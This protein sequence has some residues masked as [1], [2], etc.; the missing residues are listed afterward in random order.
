LT[1]LGGSFCSTNTGLFCANDNIG[2][3][4]VIKIVERTAG[5]VFTNITQLTVTIDD[6]IFRSPQLWATYRSN[7]FLV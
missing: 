3:L 5:A 4:N 7:V 1:T 6:F 2:N